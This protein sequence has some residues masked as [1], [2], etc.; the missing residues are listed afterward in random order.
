MLLNIV[1][2]IASGEIHVIPSSLNLGKALIL[3]TQGVEGLINTS[4]PGPISEVLSPTLN[5]CHLPT[6]RP[7][8]A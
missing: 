6:F 3:S 7:K 4:N 8:A 2:G 1:A 5:K